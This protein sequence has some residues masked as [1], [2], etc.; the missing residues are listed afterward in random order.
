MSSARTRARVI[1]LLYAFCALDLI[2]IYPH[3]ASANEIGR[4]V[5]A[6]GLVEHGTLDTRWSEPLVGPLVDAARFRGHVY[7][8]KAPGLALLGLPAYLGARAVLGPP[9]TANVRWSWLAMRIAAVTVPAILLGLCVVRWPEPDPFALATLL[10]A[11]PVFLYGALLFSH[12]TAAALLYASFLCLFGPPGR[13]E[14]KPR[15]LLGGF[16]CGLGVVTEYTLA[17]PAIVLAAALLFAPGRARR[18]ARFAAGGAVWALLL[19]IYDARLF[20]SPFSL[21]AG[22]EAS[23]NTAGLAARGIFGVGWPTAHGIWAVTGS[24]SR[25]LLA[26]SPVLIA[27]LVALAPRAGLRSWTRMALVLT[28]L[29][30]I[31]GYPASHGGW[32]VGARYP[33]PIV[34]FIVDAMHERRVSPNALTAGLFTFSVVLCALPIFTFPFAP[35]D[36]AFPHATFTRPLLAAGFWTPSLG[37]FAVPGWPALLPV[38][39]GVVAAASLALREGGRGALAGGLAGL[40]LAAAV[41]LAPI[42][43]TPNLA[44]QRAL[45]LDTHFRPAGRLL[46]RAAATADPAEGAYLQFLARAAAA[47]RRLA[48]DDWPYLGGEV[49]RP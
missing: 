48:P 16:L 10:F 9:A 28:F 4:W 33:L 39:L 29:L 24:F 37:N 35:P 36:Y 42:A 13:P 47:T 14:A 27:G 6:A 2:P 19:G 22:H 17:L 30:A 12:V 26:F 21:S 46:R 3:F 44:T 34:A 40:L 41:V 45:L 20:G 18:L 15:D 43:D 38:A 8:N 23:A 11:T 5:D 25:G 1:L 32:G 31:A 49:T 7:S